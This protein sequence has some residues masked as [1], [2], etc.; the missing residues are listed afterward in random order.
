MNK[1]KELAQALECIR[2]GRDFNLGLPNNDFIYMVG[3]MLCMI[4]DSEPFYYDREL[5]SWRPL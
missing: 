5:K 4:K 3:E 2:T 1:K